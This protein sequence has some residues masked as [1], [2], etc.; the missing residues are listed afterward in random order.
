MGKAFVRFR[1]QGW[2]WAATAVMRTGGCF[3]LGSPS[4]S[5]ARSVGSLGSSGRK[6]RKGRGRKPL[7][8]RA[9]NRS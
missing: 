9:A 8:K 3:S 5:R 1:E 4:S 7:S 6:G 2:A